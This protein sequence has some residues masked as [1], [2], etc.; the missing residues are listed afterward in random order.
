MIAAS[1]GSDWLLNK[2]PV[3]KLGKDRRKRSRVPSLLSSRKSGLRTNAQRLLKLS[4]R[5]CISEV[6]IV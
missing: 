5:Q 4:Y 1:S 6:L 3:S 2:L